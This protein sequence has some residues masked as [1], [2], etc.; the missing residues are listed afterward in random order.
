MTAQRV[1]ILCPDPGRMENLVRVPSLKGV[2]FSF[3][4]DWQGGSA[5]LRK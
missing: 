4:A 1:L 2:H 5:A 3:L